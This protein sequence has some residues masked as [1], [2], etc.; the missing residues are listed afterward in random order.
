MAS[1][2]EPAE[3]ALSVSPDPAGAENGIAVRS[4]AGAGRLV[5]GD[6][7]RATRPVALSRVEIGGVCVLMN[8]GLMAVRE[9]GGW[10]AYVGFLALVLG[11]VYVFGPRYQA[12]GRWRI[13]R[14]MKRARVRAR[15]E[16][17]RGE[18]TR[19][20]GFVKA[21]GRT[22]RTVTGREAVVARYLGTPGAGRRSWFRRTRWELHAMDFELVSDGGETVGVQVDGLRFVGMPFDAGSF[23]IKLGDGGD[24]AAKA[25]DGA[26]IHDEDV[27]G[28]GDRIEVAGILDFAP[29]PLA[30]GGDRQGKLL[31]VIGGGGRPVYLR[32]GP[33][34]AIG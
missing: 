24:G 32:R 28:P 33:P 14:A 30:E 29:H 10:W 19:V 20:A 22:F 17:R 6:T 2:K 27:V 3:S 12:I 1:E 13:G 4:D 26:A 23:Q 18:W 7:W 11:A 34:W 15:G 25:D 5:L 31:P 8:S 16:G 21:G 9:F